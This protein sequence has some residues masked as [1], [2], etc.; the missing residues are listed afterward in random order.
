MPSLLFLFQL[1]KPPSPPSPVEPVPPGPPPPFLFLFQDS[2]FRELANWIIFTGWASVLLLLIIVA[3]FLLGTSQ[4]RSAWWQY[5]V[6][7]LIGGIGL[8]SLVVVY[9]GYQQWSDFYE[10][11]PAHGRGFVAGLLKTQRQYLAAIQTCQNQF[12]LLAGILVVLLG[13]AIWQLLRASTKKDAQTRLEDNRHTHLWISCVLL[14]IG[15]CCLPFG[16]FLITAYSP[17]YAP[18]AFQYE[19]STALALI[20]LFTVSLGGPLI[21]MLLGVTSIVRQYIVP[22][23]SY[24][25]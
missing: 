2:F 12:A 25:S 14:V 20:G 10:R 16:A 15:F 24:S 1:V 5:L 23:L 21:L 19:G 13:I 9:N 22:R 11:L 6:L 4:K 3:F 17:F 18:Q 7:L 8:W